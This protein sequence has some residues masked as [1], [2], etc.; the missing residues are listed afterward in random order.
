MILEVQEENAAAGEDKANLVFRVGVLLVEAGEHGVEAGRFGMDI[1]NIRRP[2]AATPLELIDLLGVGREHGLGRSV[3]GH[4]RK[5]PVLIVD[6]Q[7]GKGDAH[8]GFILRS[9]GHL[10]GNEG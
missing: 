6:A 3:G 7:S 10:G 9:S 2:V 1:D 5:V 4:A 8:F